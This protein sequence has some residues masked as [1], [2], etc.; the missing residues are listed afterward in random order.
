MLKVRWFYATDIPTT[1]PV[2]RNYVQTKRATEFLPFAKQDS[3]RIEASFKLYSNTKQDKYRIVPVNE[4]QLF[5]CDLK[6][7][8]LRPAYW[9]G[10][11]YEV[12]RGT[13][14][15]ENTPA[16]DS[17]SSQL[18]KA[19]AEVKPYDRKELV[20]TKGDEFSVRYQ[21]DFSL[22][23]EASIYEHE[24]GKKWPYKDSPD[25]TL[26]PKDVVFTD[27]KTAVL[28]DQEIGL[29]KLVVDAFAKTRKKSLMGVYC[30]T[31]G[32]DEASEKEREKINKTKDAKKDEKD[33]P[34]DPNKKPSPNDLMDTIKKTLDYE[35]SNEKFQTD[36]END[37]ANDPSK[38][39]NSGD[40]EVDHLILCIHGVGQSLSA[41]FSNVN[42]AHD[43]SNFRQMIK[44]LFVKNPT[45]YAKAAYPEGTDLESP[46]VRNCKV[47][48]LPIIWRYNV[49]FSWEHVYKEYAA[50]GS[51]RLPKL[52]DL[53]INGT[54]ALRTLAADTVLDILLYYEPGYKKQILSSVVRTANGL[55]DKYLQ[56][57]PNFHG[58]VS[59]CGHSLGSVIAMDLLCAQP[60]TPP[61]K[62]DFNP[63]VHLKFPVENYFGMGSPNGVFKL[64]KRQNIRP[65]CDYHEQTNR[66]NDPIDLLSK[67]E[68]SPKVNN[69]YNIFYPTDI[70]AYRIEPVV[71]T[72]MS[73]YK[74]AT[75][76]SVDVN[77]I[78]SKIQSLS[79]LPAGILDNKVAK[80]LFTMTGLENQ[81]D[82]ALK[83]ALTAST[84]TPTELEI[85]ETASKM[86]W[87]LNKNGRLDYSLP[88]G[89]FDIDVINALGC[90][91]Q[92]L[93]DPNVAS[94]IL[95]EL[96][97][98]G[99]PKLMGVKKDI[100]VIKVD[101]Q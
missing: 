59:I 87:A 16:P 30:L 72:C 94:F 20:A 9:N 95:N 65:R 57:H 29:R 74:P 38:I 85:P 100:S 50:D 99:S 45:K 82:K 73:S 71:H 96:W 37:F 84:Q 53:N 28:V 60:D 98:P 47:Q 92:Y 51:L 10:P 70:V 55:Y 63:D 44:K 46:E 21:S 17:V 12:R 62:K 33:K 7:R 80:T 97:S 26:E 101:K 81:Y 27:E 68:V 6:E 86:L 18:E 43:C 69:A 56:R 75:I 40:R 19:Y 24:S 11:S 77:S 5:D 64:M 58:K 39:E 61:S 22:V 42:F 8:L 83:S 3:D 88:Q 90:H 32:Y 67:R 66:V 25:L 35:F 48:V 78:T 36:M 49:D 54:N 14:F 76:P 4:D 79:S 52:L 1:K 13:W 34:K 15:L 31:R 41:V 93:K 91:T 2:E 23:P 89:Y